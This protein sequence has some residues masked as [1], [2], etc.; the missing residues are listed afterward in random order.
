MPDLDQQCDEGS[1]ENRGYRERSW[2]VDSALVIEVFRNPLRI[3][4]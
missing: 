2:V 1:E 4:K 3:R